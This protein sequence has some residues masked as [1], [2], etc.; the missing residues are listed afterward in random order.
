MLSKFKF[1]FCTF[2]YCYKQKLIEIQDNRRS[3]I[4]SYLSQTNILFVNLA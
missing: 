4:I 1:N 3:T 2:A